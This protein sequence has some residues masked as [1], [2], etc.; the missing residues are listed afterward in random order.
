METLIEKP[1]SVC[2]LIKPLADFYVGS[3]RGHRRADCKPCYYARHKGSRKGYYIDRGNGFKA[4]AIAAYGGFCYCCGE[5]NI[6]LL[7]LDH[8]FNDGN[9]SRRQARANRAFRGG[10]D[11]YRYLQLQ[12]YPQDLG[13]R[14]AC[15]NCNCGRQYNSNKG[16]C[17]HQ[18][19]LQALTGLRLVA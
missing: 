8:S 5:D 12:G 9:V 10:R 2:K 13:L 6:K 16:V 19:E 17:P 7:T 3:G 4:D 1:C 14:A 15:W 18:E 11:F